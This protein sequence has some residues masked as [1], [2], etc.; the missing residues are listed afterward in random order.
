M[1]LKYW[2]N[3]N[4]FIYIYIDFIDFIDFYLIRLYTV[5][6]WVLLVLTFIDYLSITWDFV[7]KKEKDQ[8]LQGSTADGRMGTFP[9]IFTAKIL[10]NERVCQVLENI[11]LCEGK[12][13][14]KIYR[15][16]ARSLGRLQR[17][18]TK[19][20]RR[21]FRLC[22]TSRMT[23]TVALFGFE[24]RTS[25]GQSAQSTT[26]PSSNSD[27]WRNNSLRNTVF[28]QLIHAELVC[29]QKMFYAT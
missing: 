13:S 4:D 25:T 23:A 22:S 6:L 9:T 17:L 12:K 19:N 27:F 24:P 16:Q 21:C 7:L 11:Q 20:S 8:Y 15:H 26:S 1:P 2:W 14:L 29:L 5:Y 3:I 10:P 28:L 18:N